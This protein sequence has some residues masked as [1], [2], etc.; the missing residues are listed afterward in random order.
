[1]VAGVLLRAPW[2]V[3]VAPTVSAEVKAGKFCRLFAPVSGSCGSFGRAP[4]V[5]E[6]YALLVSAWT[7]R[8]RMGVSPG[9]SS[10]WW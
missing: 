4:V 7:Q 5:A 8:D 9:R 3:V 6:V 1:V 2:M 10:R